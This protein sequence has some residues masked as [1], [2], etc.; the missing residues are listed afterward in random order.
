MANI[1]NIGLIAALGVVAVL[2]LGAAN[3]APTPVSTPTPAVVTLAPDSRQ[4]ARLQRREPR[5]R[6]AGVLD[7]RR[8]RKRP[9]GHDERRLRVIDGA[10]LGDDDR[11]R[12]RDAGDGPDEAG[13]ERDGAVSHDGARG[14]EL[15][16]IDGPRED[17]RF[18]PHEHMAG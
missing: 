11:A 15:P 6:P 9:V 16:G 5:G 1:R 4:P 14:P 10:R 7:E 13:P 12:P 3:D 18:R 17:T 8:H 2:T